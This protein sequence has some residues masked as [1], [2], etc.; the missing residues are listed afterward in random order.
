LQT[1]NLTLRPHIPAHLIAL[2]ESE[3]AYEKISGCKAA[4]G[5][6]KF[7]LMA[8]PEFFQSLQS[9]SEPDPWKF[10]FAI[11]HTA[12]NL[13][14]G[15]C[16][17]AG[18]PDAER[19]VEIGYSIAPAYQGQGLATEAA[20]ALIDFATPNQ[21]RKIRAH[22]LAKIN[23]STR[24]LEKCEFIKTAENVDPEGK[25]VWRWERSCSSPCRG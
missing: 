2:R 18:P 9:G 6:R 20:R 10:G 15:L 23:A 8:S 25:L 19:C 17:F 21:V 7:L 4:P 13:V 1:K 12:D 11:F 3:N 22:T 16:G 14:I 5:I 24:V